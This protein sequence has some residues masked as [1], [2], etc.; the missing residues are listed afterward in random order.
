MTAYIQIV[1]RNHL[2]YLQACIESC[3]RQTV[4]VPILYIDNASTDDSVPFVRRTFPTVQ[5]IENRTNRGYSG[6][7]NDGIRAHSHSDVVIVLNPDVVLMPDF[8]EH[9]LKQFVSERVGAVAPLLLRPGGQTIDAY[10]DVLLQTLRPVNHYAH[11]SLAVFGHLDSPVAPWGVTGA[12]AF[13]RRQAL[14]EISVNGEIFDEQ[15]FAYREDA[16]C[17]WRL[18]NHDWE[19]HGVPQARA[20]HVRAV[21]TGEPKDPF[22]AQLSW[23][24]YALLLLKNAP[25]ELLIRRAPW[26]IAESIARSVQ[27]LLSPALWPALPAL[28]RLIAPA[29]AKRRTAHVRA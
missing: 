18:R 17:S 21:R 2:Q 6:G 5:V 12:A 27:L 8:V 15:F 9:G 1:G 22:I 26:V 24:N 20:T 7:H 19:I 16:D 29:L 13:L 28:L 25:M 23:R 14:E 4:P 3:L 10:G 11:M